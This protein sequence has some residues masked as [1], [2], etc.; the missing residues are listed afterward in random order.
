V[1][2]PL[3]TTG[4]D[5]CPTKNWVPAFAGMT[6]RRGGIMGE[7]AA[8]RHK[9]DL[10]A[11]TKI[12]EVQEAVRLIG[13]LDRQIKSNEL[14]MT[15][16][17]EEIKSKH[18]I[19][20][21]RLD[22]ERASLLALVQ[23]YAV[24]HR[25]ELLGKNKTVKLTHGK[26]GWRKISEKIEPFP[27]KGSDEMDDLVTRIERL[28]EGGGMA[29]VPVHTTKYVMKTA[30]KGLAASV[31]KLLGLERTNSFD[32]FF[33]EAHKEKLPDTPDVAEEGK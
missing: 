3:K 9:G 7:A 1:N 30:F 15:K 29:E 31:L 26:L 4:R 27:K 18:E 19:A 11:I 33:V 32:E 23:T 13:R 10:G 8:I 20:K 28:Q 21:G 5:A 6:D 24:A 12:E 16:E 25:D 2:R 17:I 22:A 14:T